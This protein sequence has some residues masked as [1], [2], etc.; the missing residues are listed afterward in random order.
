MKL[1]VSEDSVENAYMEHF[2][3]G[4]FVFCTN[5]QIVGKHKDSVEK[6]RFGVINVGK[7]YV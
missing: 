5:L 3:Y 4:K 1:C 7:Q 6:L 2:S